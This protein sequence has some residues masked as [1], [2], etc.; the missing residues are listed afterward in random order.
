MGGVIGAVEAHPATGVLMG[1]ELPSFKYSL[2]AQPAT[3]YGD[4]LVWEATTTQFPASQNLSGAV[5]RLKPGALRELHWHSHASEW[6]YVLEGQCRVITIDPENNAEVADFGKGDVWYFPRGFGHSFQATG[7]GDCVIVIAFDKGDMSYGTFGLSDWFGHAPVEVLRKNFGVPAE[8]FAGFPKHELFIAQGRAPGPVPASPPAGSLA[9]PPLTHRY[10]LLGQKPVDYEF[11]SKR[12][13]TQKQFPISATMSGA[14]LTLKP[15]GLRELH[16]H[17]N[18]DEWQYYVAGKA[19]MT[20][21]GAGGRA[22][23]DEFG[24]GD[25]GYAPQGFGHYIENIGADDLVC[26]L[27][28]NN[29]NFNS[30]SS[31]GWLAATPAEVLA[32]NL[33]VPAESFAAFPKEE[34]FI[35][36]ASA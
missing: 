27:A 7:S 4:S 32:T 13:V 3:N 36:G 28:F 17:P 8:L 20:V 12:I 10:H 1:P 22:R 2:L 11:G 23:T 25:I 16:W 26:V 34:H 19:R 6:A 15:G 18:A 5:M 24:P 29:G 35:T 31:T 9:S 21:F 14:L 33:G 30:I